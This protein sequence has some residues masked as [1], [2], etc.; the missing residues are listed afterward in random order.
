M[1]IKI[2]SHQEGTVTE[3]FNKPSLRV[4]L[5]PGV[6]GMP[7]SHPLVDETRG[8]QRGSWGRTGGLKQQEHMGEGRRSVA[9]YQ[10]IRGIVIF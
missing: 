7:R 2:V 6:P 1:I 4:E 10:L 8:D 5:G 9:K 3:Q